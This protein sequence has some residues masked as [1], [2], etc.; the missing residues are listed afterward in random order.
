MHCSNHAA[1]S[2]HS[3]RSEAIQKTKTTQPGVV[4][5]TCRYRPRYERTTEI[6]SSF[7]VTDLTP[8]GFPIKKSS[9]SIRES[10]MSKLSR[11]AL[12]SFLFLAALFLSG[13]VWMQ[14]VRHTSFCTTSSCDVVG[15]YIR[16][17]EG[18]LIKLGA[19]FFWALWSLVFF[20]GRY[21]KIWLWSPAALIFLG[22]L[23]FDGALLGFQFVAL[24]EQ[25]LLCIVVAVVLFTGLFLF[26]WVRRS[27]L[28]ACLGIAAWCGGFTANS[29]L[30]L[31]VI[32]PTIHSTAFLSLENADNGTISASADGSINGTANASANN[33]AQVPANGTRY[34]EHVLFF[35]LHCDHCA[36]IMLNLS[37]N[38]ETLP[39]NWRLASVDNKEDDLHRLA[40][41]LAAPEATRNPFLA[42]LRVESLDSVAP[43]DIPDNLRQTVREARTYFKTKGYLGVPILIVTERPG[44]EVVLRGE[45]SIMRYLL[46]NGILKRTLFFAPPESARPGVDD[47]TPQ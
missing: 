44:W 46:K 18:N 34:P 13:E 42:T 12:L 9:T 5:P 8:P 2:R 22:A 38:T 41:I 20:A 7:P 36:K 25:C 47:A 35:S 21:D 19:V 39:G 32:P 16:F 24:R 4:R 23:A 40:H 26:A 3:G 15:E 28:L 27:L 31:D 37:V 17:G 43:I 10:A 6:R 29:V 30:D 45:V 1:L 33:T 14:A 11:Y